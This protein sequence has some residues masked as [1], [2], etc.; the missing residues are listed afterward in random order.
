MLPR[1][2][3]A[4]SNLGL[5][6]FCSYMLTVS[7]AAVYFNWKYAHQN[8]FGTWLFFGQVVPSLKAL[9]WPYFAVVQ[10]ATPSS[11]ED[12]RPVATA[13]VGPPLNDEQLQRLAVVS[14]RLLSSAPQDSDVREVRSVLNDYERRTGTRLSKVQFEHEVGTVRLVLEYKCELGESALISWDRERRVTTPAFERLRNQITDLI[15]GDQ[16]QED[17]RL[18]DVASRRQ[19]FI[20]TADGKRFEFSRDAIA[21]GLEKRR[22]QVQSFAKLTNSVADLLR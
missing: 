21:G 17:S 15:P 10:D 19:S 13:D 20:D 12:A 22:Q 7:C 1:A 11:L 6:V 2:K 3:K 9:V 4:L 8:G 5:A 14:K 18:I 16:I